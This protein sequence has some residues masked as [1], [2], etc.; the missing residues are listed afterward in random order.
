MRK[1][2]LLNDVICLR[3][4]PP[5]EHYGSI[6]IPGHLRM[7]LWQGTVLACGPGV[8][9]GYKVD[10]PHYED[11]KQYVLRSCNWDGRTRVKLDVHVG[12]HV[13]VGRQQAEEVT[14][15]GERL[16]FTRQEEIL[17]VIG[18]GEE[19]KHLRGDWIEKNVWCEGDPA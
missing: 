8:R 12:D 13:L 18:E 19:V 1:L 5:D 3:Q 16:L 6:I 10:R 9:P 14:F 4:G 17:A 15:G 2:R 7:R 11:G